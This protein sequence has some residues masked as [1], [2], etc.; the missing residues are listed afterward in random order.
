[1]ITS[2][3]TNSQPL[4]QDLQLSPPANAG[5]ASAGIY[6]RYPLKSQA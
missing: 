5:E 3:F 6:E 4:H 1:M 2:F